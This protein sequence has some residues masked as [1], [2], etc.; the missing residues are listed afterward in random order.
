MATVRIIQT[1]MPARNRI[2]NTMM[3]EKAGKQKTLL[4]LCN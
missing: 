2:R 4:H 3:P 1:M